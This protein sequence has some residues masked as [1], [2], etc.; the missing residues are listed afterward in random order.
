M[1][2]GF[3]LGAA[4]DA[5]KQ[6]ALVAVRRLGLRICIGFPPGSFSPCRNL[7]RL[8]LEL[9]L[10][11]PGMYHPRGLAKQHAASAR[12]PRTLV[13]LQGVFSSR[14]EAESMRQ[15]G[16][17]QGSGRNLG[18]DTQ[19]LLSNGTA[20]TRSA[21]CSYTDFELKTRSVSALR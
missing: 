20:V 12:I 18:Q 8:C 10:V 11:Q 19:T 13:K 3:C 6:I 17:F 9:A 15:V 1:A 5:G 7:L 21:L 4:V 16:Q 2:S 14:S